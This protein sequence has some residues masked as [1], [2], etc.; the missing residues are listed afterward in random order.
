AIDPIIDAF[1]DDSDRVRVFA[2]RTLHGICL[3]HRVQLS[4]DHLESTLSQLLDVGQEELRLAV[5][6]L[7]QAAYPQDSAALTLIIKALLVN[8]ERHPSEKSG[9]FSTLATLGKNNSGLFT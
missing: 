3:V 7:L 8:L 5:R 4:G 6:G 9:I 1:N 2:V